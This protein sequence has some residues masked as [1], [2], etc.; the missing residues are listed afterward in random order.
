[1]DAFQCIC[2]TED[3]ISVCLFVCLSTDIMYG[4]PYYLPVTPRRVGACKVLE[5]SE[6][7]YPVRS[8]RRNKGLCWLGIQT[9]T[10]SALYSAS[11]RAYSVPARITSNTSQPTRGFLHA[12]GFPVPDTENG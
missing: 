11:D 5:D 3:E 6:S 9:G 1:M 12:E 7:E 4:T 10:R 2:V 8:I